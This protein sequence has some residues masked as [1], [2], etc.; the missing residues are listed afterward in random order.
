METQSSMLTFFTWTK[1]SGKI[2]TTDDLR[3]HGIIVVDCCCMCKLN[4]ETAYIY[5]VTVTLLGKCVLL[6]FLCLGFTWVMPRTVAELYVR[7][8]TLVDIV[9][10]KFGSNS[11]VYNVM[12][13][14]RKECT[15]F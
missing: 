4:G 8:D 12:Y 10:V 7:R 11:F 14:E 1:M 5:F 13:L 2:L 9:L 6:C 3:K 15:H